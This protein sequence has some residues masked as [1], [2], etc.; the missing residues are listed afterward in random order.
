LSDDNEDDFVA[1][2]AVAREE[3]EVFKL[4]IELQELLKKTLM[5]IGT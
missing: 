1:Q 2:K 3:A 5:P 4:K